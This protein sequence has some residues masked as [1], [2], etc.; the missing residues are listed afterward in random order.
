MYAT[1][2]CTTV[3][4]WLMDTANALS[5]STCSRGDHRHCLTPVWNA[6]N[7][8][9]KLVARCADMGKAIVHQVARQVS[10]TK[11]RVCGAPRAG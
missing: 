11:T 5:G 8:N 3:S 7:C 4:S 1:G 2:P 6:Y 9:R 10:Q